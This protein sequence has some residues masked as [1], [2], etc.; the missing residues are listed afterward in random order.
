MPHR[1]W[2]AM[3]RSRSEDVMIWQVLGGGRGEW[4]YRSWCDDIAL[5]CEDSANGQP[6]V[7]KDVGPRVQLLFC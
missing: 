1:L 6:V 2:Y 3:A 5:H 4:A 7:V